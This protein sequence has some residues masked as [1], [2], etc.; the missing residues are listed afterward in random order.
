MLLIR[1][2]ATMHL[3]E[4][5][6]LWRDYYTAESDPNSITYGKVYNEIYF[7]DHIYDFVIHPQWDSMGSETLFFKQLYVDYQESFCVI[8]LLGEWNDVINNDVMY[9][10]TELINPLIEAGIENYILVMENVLNFHAD[11]NDYYLEWKD[12]V[13]GEIFLINALPQVIEELN[14][15]D[16]KSSIWFDGMLNEIDWRLQK[17]Y[18]LLEHIQ[19]KLSHIL[20]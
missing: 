10:K 15:L 16:I 9:L 6:Y 3:I 2:I 4:P 18:Q 8:E 13:Q 17:P 1:P 7:T 12:E 20:E 11:Q 19:N 14:T 5:F